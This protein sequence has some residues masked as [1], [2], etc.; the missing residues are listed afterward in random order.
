MIQGHVFS[1]GNGT[2]VREKVKEN[3]CAPEEIKLISRK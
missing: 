1:Q 3:N 2:V